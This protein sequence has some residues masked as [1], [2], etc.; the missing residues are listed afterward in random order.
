[1]VDVLLD[2][3]FYKYHN[4]RISCG[5]KD[6]FVIPGW[7]CFFH[8]SCEAI[9]LPQKERID[10]GNLRGTIN[11]IPTSRKNPGA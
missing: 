10:H 6:T 5:L 7:V 2:H 9:V 4:D 1:M 8:F 11:T 3:N